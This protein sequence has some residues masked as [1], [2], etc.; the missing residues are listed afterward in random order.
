MKIEY[1]IGRRVGYRV[2][3]NIMTYR[4]VLTLGSGIGISDVEVCN[5]FNMC[6]LD[7]YSSI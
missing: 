5:L 1:S 4:F 2:F 6:V 3:F 7:K